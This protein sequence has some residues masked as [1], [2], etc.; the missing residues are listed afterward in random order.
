M[1]DF[2]GIAKAVPVLTFFMLFSVFASAGLPGLNGFIGEF[3]ILLGSWKS[4]VLP[5]WIVVV[6]TT[7]VILAA[8]Y[9]LW[10]TYAT[11]HGALTSEANAAMKDLNGREVGLL[12]PLAIGM[13]VLGFWPA[14]CWTSRPF[15]RPRLCP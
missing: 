12:M 2:G 3:L 10:M 8:V 5:T 9:L 15:A 1:A 11:F 13:L 6:S 4:A 14:P 7:G